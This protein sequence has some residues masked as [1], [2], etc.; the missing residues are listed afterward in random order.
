MRYPLA[1]DQIA[2]SH[3]AQRLAFDDQLRNDLRYASV[4]IDDV[5]V[6]RLRMA[7]AG[8][9]DDDELSALVG[10]QI[11][12]FRLAGNLDAEAGSQEWRAIARALCSAELEALAR[13]A[14]RDEGDYSGQPTATI[15]KD[16][17]PLEDLSQPVSVKQLWSDYVVRRQKLGYMRDGGRR[18]VLAVDSLVSFLRHDDAA[19]ISKKNMTEWL[20]HTLTQKHPTTI[21]KVYL[22][23]IRSL[24]KWAVEKELIKENPAS[25]IRL[26]TLKKTQTR[27]RGYTDREALKVLM[28]TQSYRPKTSPKGKTLE[29]PKTTA[30]K[31]WIPWLCAFSGA[32][33]AEIAQLR[34]EDFREEDGAHVVRITPDAGGTKTS[35]WRDVPLHPQIVSLGFLRYVDTIPNGPIFHNATK[36]TDYLHHA[37]KMANRVGDWLHEENLVPPG[38][39]P[40]HGWRHRFKTVGRELEIQDRVLDAIQG[41]APRTSGGDYGDVTLKTKVEAISKMPKFDLE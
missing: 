13:V 8:R 29:A 37:K 31:V 1:P 20:D 15:I 27:E 3:Y 5:L 36:P 35:G 25:D 21:S 26:P 16:A 39:Q 18:Q 32:R 10:A 11:E 17:Q 9:A 23:T 7:T 14:E 4:G 30:A 40:S 12:R 28:A 6:S 41:H 19:K 2:H 22:P 38:V 33:V 24:F 34:R